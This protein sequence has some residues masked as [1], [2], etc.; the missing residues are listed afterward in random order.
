MQEKRIR[1][2]IPASLATEID[3]LVGKRTR[4][5][6]VAEAARHEVRRLQQ[7]RALQNACG[8]WKDADHPDLRQGSA[9][10]V[11]RMRGHS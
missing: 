7:L 2:A 3:T 6:F 9:R 1:I 11:A 8:A 5:A 10:W 4:G